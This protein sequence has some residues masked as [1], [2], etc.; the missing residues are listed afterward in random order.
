[1]IEKT[2]KYLYKK[3]DLQSNISFNMVALADGKPKTLGLK[4]MLEYYVEHQKE[5][6][7][8]RTKRELEIAEKRFHIVEGFIK[9]IGIMDEI[10]KL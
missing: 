1:M 9:A 5:V 6:I 7:T 2:L 4:A 3:T 10:I 8:R